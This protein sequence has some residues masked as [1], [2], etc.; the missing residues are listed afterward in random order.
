MLGMYAAA[1]DMCSGYVDRCG[2]AGKARSIIMATTK[3]VALGST[4]KLT[5]A[6]SAMHETTHTNAFCN[7]DM[8][9][10]DRT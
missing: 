1:V 2:D 4:W 5:S 6:T 9:R 7:F 8:S 3:V 10:L